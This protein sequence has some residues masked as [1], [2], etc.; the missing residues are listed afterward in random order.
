MALELAQKMGHTKLP[1]G[2]NFPVGS[3]FWMRSNVLKSFVDLNLDWVDYPAEPISDDGTILHALE[4]LFGII[5][6]LAG[7]KSAVTNIRG[8]TR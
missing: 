1:C 3:M 6:I 7:W 5:P 4:R 8:V 2:I